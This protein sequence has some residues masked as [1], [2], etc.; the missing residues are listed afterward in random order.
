MDAP[1]L[2]DLRPTPPEDPKTKP[3]LPPSNTSKTTAPPSPKRTAKHSKPKSRP[4]DDAASAYAYANRWGYGER[5]SY[6]DRSDR[7]WSYGRGVMV[8]RW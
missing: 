2:V 1:E 4:V 6:A 8:D 5:R 7:G 3:E